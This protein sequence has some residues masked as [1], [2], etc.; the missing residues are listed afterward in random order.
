MSI[1]DGTHTYQLK[2]P[3]I[4]AHGGE[5]LEASYLV[6]SE[7]NP[8]HKRIYTRIKRIVDNAIQGMTEKHQDRIEKQP[9]PS[10]PVMEMSDEDYKVE[11]QD[12]KKM[13]EHSL[14]TVL[15][16]EEHDRFYDIMR[17]LLCM[18]G[19]GCVCK[20]DGKE[21]MKQLIYDDRLSVEDAN[22]IALEYCAFFGIGLL[23][24]LS[25]K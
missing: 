8:S 9:T 17:E 19:V 16:D 14:S 13:L 10:K 3:F 18:G 1:Q 24:E 20:I 6:L 7:F 5:E 2:K 11:F 23:G 25:A 21:P 4:Y 15:S 12:M 22:D